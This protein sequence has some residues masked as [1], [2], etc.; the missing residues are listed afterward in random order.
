MAEQILQEKIIELEDT[1]IKTKK[2]IKHREKKNFLESE[3][4]SFEQWN[5]FPKFI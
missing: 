3:T 5:N 2:K 4:V 1:A